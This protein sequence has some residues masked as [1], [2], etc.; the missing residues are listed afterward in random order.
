MAKVAGV[1]V[2][3]YVNTGTDLTPVY[4]VLG[5]QGDAKLDR[6]AKEIDVTAKTDNSGYEDKLVG[7]KNWSLD[8]DGFIV[9]DDT[10]LDLLEQ[11]FEDRQKVMLEIRMPSGKKYSGSA[12][13]TDFPLDFKQDDGAAYSLKLSGASALTITPAV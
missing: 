10:A 11:I 7:K 8:C 4:T 6:G 12:V 5:G 9:E 3:L 13:I 2:L 1:D